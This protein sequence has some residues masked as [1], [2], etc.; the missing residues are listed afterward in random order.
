MYAEL[1]QDDQLLIAIE[2]HLSGS[3]IPNELIGLLGE[4]VIK[5]ITEPLVN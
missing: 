5:D 1:S 4:E 2:F 3:K